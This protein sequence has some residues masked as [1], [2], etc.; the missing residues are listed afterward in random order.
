MAV[1]IAIDGRT[2]ST[3]ETEKH[4]S[5]KRAVLLQPD[6]PTISSRL[7]AMINFDT[8]RQQHHELSIGNDT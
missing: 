6:R 4:N 7:V 2:E 5:G 8:R 3:R 1:W